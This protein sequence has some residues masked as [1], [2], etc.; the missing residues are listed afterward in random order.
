MAKTK[1]KA[2]IYPRQSRSTEKFFWLVAF[3]QNVAK[4]EA[5]AQAIDK[6]SKEATWNWPLFDTLAVAK[7]TLIDDQKNTVSYL[8]KDGLLL[9][10]HQDTTVFE[11]PAG[12][13]A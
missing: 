13:A 11:Q 6:T 10:A 3:F 12:G 5:V 4:L 1:T 9:F 8:V 2:L 7:H